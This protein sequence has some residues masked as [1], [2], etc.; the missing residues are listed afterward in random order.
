MSRAIIH[1]GSGKTGS[2][3]IQRALF[4]AS[5]RGG[6]DGFDYPT[7]RGWHH[8]DLYIL[9]KSREALARNLKSQIRSGQVEYEKYRKAYEK[10]LSPDGIGGKDLILSSE[11]LFDLSAENVRALRDLLDRSGVTEY[12]VIA[13]VR[14]PA[15]YYLSYVQQRLKA[16]H[17]IPHPRRFRYRLKSALSVWGEVFGNVVVRDFDELADRGGDAVEA[18]SEIVGSAGWGSL[19]LEATRVNSGLCAE[20]MVLMQRYRQRFYPGAGNVF[21]PDS[22]RLLEVVSELGGVGSR[23]RLKEDVKALVSKR[24]ES[25]VAYLKQEFGVLGKEDAGTCASSR[26]DW[27]SE[28]PVQVDSLLQ[29]LSDDAVRDFNLL[30]M[31]QLLTD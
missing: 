4:E 29:G 20:A 11:Y 28:Q 18:F 25:D 13:F 6:L 17:L 19:E 31:R 5:R 10:A 3:A 7:I 26:I 22:D 9:F 16:S 23:P 30:V 2:T 1:I 8:R 24:H 14:H 12:M 27:K 21:K 15:S